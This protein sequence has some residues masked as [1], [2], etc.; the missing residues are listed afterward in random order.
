MRL[1]MASCVID[2]LRLR[3]F[4]DDLFDDRQQAVKIAALKRDLC[5][6]LHLLP[7]RPILAHARRARCRRRRHFFFLPFF[8]YRGCGGKVLFF[9]SFFFVLRTLSVTV[10]VTLPVT[11]FVILDFLLRR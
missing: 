8:S 5:A 9:R 3:P 1:L 4:F 10:F 6:L 2:S 7:R 11:V